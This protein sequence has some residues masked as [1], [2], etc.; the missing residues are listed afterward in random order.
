MPG[1]PAGLGF[2]APYRLARCV[3]GLVFLASGASKIVRLGYFAQAI[4][5]FGLVAE[6]LVPVVASGLC[7]VE[8]AAGL[9][10]LLDLRGSLAVVVGLLMLFSGV[11]AYGL[12]LGLDLECSC[13]GPDMPEILRLD[14]RGALTRN[15]VLLGVC[16]LLYL[17]RAACGIRPRRPAE[18]VAAVFR[19]NRRSPS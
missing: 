17:W 13:F 14:L 11:L 2:G 9:G 4:S 12:T 1:A 19:S 15:L 16:G 5:D 10:L 8:I 18:V 3:L 7:V 6:P